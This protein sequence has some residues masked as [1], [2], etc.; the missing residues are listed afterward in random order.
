ASGRSRRRRGPLR[1][2]APRGLR[3]DLGTGGEPD[4]GGAGLA[5]VRPA[6]G[7][8][9]AIV[10]W[11]LSRTETEMVRAALRRRRRRDRRRTSGRRPAQG[12]VLG[13]ALGAT[14]T[15]ARADRRVQAQRL[16]PGGGRVPRR[17]SAPLI[18]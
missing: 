13:V 14:G 3:G 15:A 8:D 6:R 11:T 16:R 9:R 18:V 5:H 2:S 7:A 10:G 12:G 1:G 4:P 17:R